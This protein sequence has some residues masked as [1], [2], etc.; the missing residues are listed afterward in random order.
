MKSYGISTYLQNYGVTTERSLHKS[1]R[2]ISS[3]SIHE[4]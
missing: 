4:V 2:K 1:E 3:R